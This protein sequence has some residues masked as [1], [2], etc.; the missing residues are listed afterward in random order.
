MGIGFRTGVRFSSPPPAGACPCTRSALL[1]VRRFFYCR[2]SILSKTQPLFLRGG[3]FP[4]R[5]FVNTQ[6]HRCD[7]LC[8]TFTNSGACPCTRSALLYVRRFFY[9]RS[10]ILSKTQ[11]LFLRGGH[12]P[13]RF[14]V[15]TQSHRCDNLCVTFTNSGACPCTRSAL[16]YVRRF[17]IAAHESLF[18]NP[19]LLFHHG[20]R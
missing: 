7:N 10:S 2:S 5:F 9:C 4:S 16:L 8:V 20:R 1:Y 18:I 12:F 19:T 13:S 11:P 6:S 17:F 15:N 14:F 3:H